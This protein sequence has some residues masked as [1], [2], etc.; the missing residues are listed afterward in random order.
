M[1]CV[2]IFVTPTSVLW[3]F[4]LLLTAN[5]ASPKKNKTI[6]ILILSLHWIHNWILFHICPYWHRMFFTK[7]SATFFT[8]HLRYILSNIAESKH[9]LFNSIQFSH[10]LI[11]YSL[12]VNNTTE[13]LC[14][15]ALQIRGCNT[16]PLCNWACYFH[17]F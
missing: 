9:P 3:L 16:L 10:T 4:I 5:L 7:L 1:N 14:Q 6:T 11:A 15:I 12:S 13:E 2:G 8:W 17:I